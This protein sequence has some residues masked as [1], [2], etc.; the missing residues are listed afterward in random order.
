MGS[1]GL[2]GYMHPLSAGNEPAIALS[3]VSVP[4]QV[5]ASPVLLDL[6]V[7]VQE[8]ERE[9]ETI[10]A[11]GQGRVGAPALPNGKRIHVEVHVVQDAQDRL[12]PELEAVLGLSKGE[13]IEVALTELHAKHVNKS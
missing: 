10:R 13:V 12:L 6:A 2:W 1:Q 3:A 11:G 9:V 7:H 5:E 4:L 8:L